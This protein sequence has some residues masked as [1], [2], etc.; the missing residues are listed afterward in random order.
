MEYKLS[1]VCRET[2]RTGKTHGIP[3]S[4]TGKRDNFLTTLVYYNVSMFRHVS[5]IVLLL[6]REFNYICARSAFIDASTIR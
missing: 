5:E 1:R 4:M 3:K 2:N 6:A